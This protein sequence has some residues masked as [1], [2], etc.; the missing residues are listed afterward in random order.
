M[1]NFD[2][3]ENLSNLSNN[4]GD[5]KSCGNLSD[6][7]WRYSAIVRGCVAFVCLCCC[8]LVLI[9]FCNR[10]R[11]G[12]KEVEDRTAHI[13]FRN[14]LVFY[15]TLAS[16]FYNLIQ[17][18]Q[19]RVGFKHK[20]TD[21]GLETFCGGIGFLNEFAA[22]IHLLVAVWVIGCFA[23]NYYRGSPTQERK[24]TQRSLEEI[25][26]FCREIL[27]L[28][29]IIIWAGIISGVPFASGSY[30][31]S[32][33][34]CWIRTVDDDCNRDEAGVVYQWLLWYGWVIAVWVGFLFLLL[35]GLAW[36]CVVRYKYRYHEHAQN[37]VYRDYH[38]NYG[39]ALFGL[40]IAFVLG[41]GL[42]TV[43]ELI[44]RV[45]TN[46]DDNFNA[47]LWY[48][49]AVITPIGVIFLP[50]SAL[51]YLGCCI[52]FDID[53]YPPNGCCI[54]HM[55]S[56]YKRMCRRN[57]GDEG[58]QLIQNRQNNIQVGDPEPA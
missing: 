8:T 13:N 46:K 21:G 48:T 26:V 27:P 49:Y 47:G 24:R 32:G 15:L 44:A 9:I 4:T 2:L 53:Q 56:C 6:R 14:R 5:S 43:L 37:E 31:L 7:D 54:K 50:I 34:W 40:F 58:R 57:R 1:A 42:L 18:M 3:R 41:Y 23:Y 36:A 33:G 16:L 11:R 25:P 22:C 29:V 10:V 55:R 20:P 12:L 38:L 19:I 39:C 17:T 52:G 35:F 28:C 30:G 45:D 51:C